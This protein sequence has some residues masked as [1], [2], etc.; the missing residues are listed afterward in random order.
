MWTRLDQEALHL[1]VDTA[2]L[3]SQALD[4]NNSLACVAVVRCCPSG[5]WWVT[6]DFSAARASQK[7]VLR[8]TVLEL[9]VITG[10][11]VL[12]HLQP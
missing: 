11:T 2:G 6:K 4:S 8:L 1:Q 3:G 12:N 10:A 5:L 9:R 7:Q